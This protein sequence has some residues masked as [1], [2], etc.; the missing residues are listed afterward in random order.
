MSIELHIFLHDSR[1]PSRDAWQRAIDELSFPVVL[2]TALNVRE[3]TGFLPTIYAGQSTGFEFYLE[4]S[5]DILSSYSHIAESV[6]DRE[7]CATFRWGGDLTEMAAALSVAAALTQLVDGV[8]YYPNDDIVY[9]RDDAVKTLS[10]D[11]SSL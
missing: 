9:G 11:L 8:Y 7:K 4:S 3:Q 2:D 10:E 5:Q 1:V 6:G